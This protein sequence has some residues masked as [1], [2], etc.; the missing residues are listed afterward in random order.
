MNK[1][2]A[3]LAV[4]ALVASPGWSEAPLPMDYVVRN[5]VLP[6]SPRDPVRVVALSKDKLWDVRFVL[7]EGCR[8]WVGDILRGT[9][10]R[11]L[12]DPTHRHEE[13]FENP[14]EAT[15]IRLRFEAVYRTRPLGQ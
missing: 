4:L 9:A 13:F 8:P 7:V 5:I 1:K 11:D 6:E 2:L 12:P 15:T 10:P 3:T 14:T